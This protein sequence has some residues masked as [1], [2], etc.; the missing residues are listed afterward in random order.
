MNE[1]GGINGTP[2]RVAVVTETNE[3]DSTE[4]AAKL[5]VKQPDILAVIGHFGSGASLAA[6]KIYEQEKLVMISSTSTSTE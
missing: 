1:A 5:L 3:P 4:K 6:A 2:L